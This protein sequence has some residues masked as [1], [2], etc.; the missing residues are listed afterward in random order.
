MGP[1]LL[2]LI[3][4]SSVNREGG[5]VHQTLASLFM[6]DPLVH[7]CDLRIMV[8]SADTSYLD[9]YRQ[10]RL[11]IEPLSTTEAEQI[12]PWSAHRRCAH[13][14]SRCLGLPLGGHPGLLAIEDDAVFR[15]G[16]LTKLAA[17]VNEIEESASE[18]VLS[19]FACYDFSENVANRRG[20]TYYNYPADS[21]YSTVCTYY[22]QAVL[23]RLVEFFREQQAVEPTD[24][25]VK[26]FCKLGTPIFASARSLAQ[27]IGEISTGCGGGKRRSRTFNLEWEHKW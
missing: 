21:F 16:F 27:H 18:Y 4:I 5:Y 7:Q 12:A 23:P 14:Y 11:Q 3:A 22:P 24:M 19:C 10:H 2:P 20:Y 8:G 13:N 17:T 15:H 9:D 25:A 26:S 6:S 1:A